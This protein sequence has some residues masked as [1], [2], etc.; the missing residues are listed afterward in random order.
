MSSNLLLSG[1]YEVRIFHFANRADLTNEHGETDTGAPLCM[2]WSVD[3]WIHRRTSQKFY[4]NGVSPSSL[5]ALRPNQ[6]LILEISVDDVLFS[7]GVEATLEQV[8]QAFALIEVKNGAFV[9]DTDIEADSIDA[10]QR[11]I[12]VKLTWKA[13]ALKQGRVYQLKLHSERTIQLTNSRDITLEL[14]SNHTYTLMNPNF[15]GP[16]G[17]LDS[18]NLCSCKE[19]YGGLDCSVCGVGYV[20]E[21]DKCVKTTIK[22]CLPCSCGCDNTNKPLGICQQKAGNIVCN[23]FDLYTGAT[24]ERCKDSSQDGTYPLCL[25]N[26]KECTVSCINGVCDHV[27]GM[28]R[29]SHYW[30]GAA[31]DVCEGRFTGENCDQCKPQFGGEGCGACSGGWIGDECTVCQEGWSGSNC[32]TKGGFNMKYLYIA[33]GVGLLIIVVVLVIFAVRKWKKRKETT[34]ATYAMTTLGMTDSEDFFDD[35]METTSP[36]ALLGDNAFN[37]HLSD[38]EEGL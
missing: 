38:D 5:S 13:G 29:C 30:N 17:V 7:G 28:C 21:G 10:N 37:L 24:C 23:C 22:V 9:N 15:C 12:G 6:D 14:F 35:H 36:H 20:A 19:G 27:H 11:R 34:R 33:G 8:R 1:S 32:D 2:P 26:P 18:D 3:M 4:V 31:C 16:N 25:G